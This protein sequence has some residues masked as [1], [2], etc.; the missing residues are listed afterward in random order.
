MTGLSIF[1]GLNTRNS[2]KTV[3]PPAQCCV[4]KTNTGV[5]YSVSVTSISWNIHAYPCC[6]I[7][8]AEYDVM[9]QPVYEVGMLSD[10]L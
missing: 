10:E 8:D 4:E 6:V 3:L 2:L 7:P 1:T 5:L 9:G